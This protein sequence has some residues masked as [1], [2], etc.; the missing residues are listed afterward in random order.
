MEGNDMG[1]QPRVFDEDSEDEET[2]PIVKLALHEDDNG[3]GTQVVLCV[4]DSD[5]DPCEDILTI[6]KDGKIL[7]HA[8]VETKGFKTNGNGH[9][10]TERE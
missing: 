9:V 10:Q 6:T 8:S 3:D 1:M 5:G 2:N 7:L 4:V